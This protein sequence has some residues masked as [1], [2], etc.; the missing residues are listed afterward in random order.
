[1]KTSPRK[2]SW[3]RRSDGPPPAGRAKVI[4]ERPT[5]LLPYQ[6]RWVKDNAR[7]KIAE[8][9]RQ[10]GWSWATAYRLVSRKSLTGGLDA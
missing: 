5:L 10:I 1:M 4:P 7:L 9:A 2:P 6:A 3:R 8:K